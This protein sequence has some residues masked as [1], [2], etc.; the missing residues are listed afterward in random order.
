M[1]RPLKQNASYFSHDADM[2]NNRKIKALRARFGLEGYAVWCMTLECLTEEN[3]FV[4]PWDELSTELIS[5]D[6]GIAAESLAEIM[7]YMA[8]VGLLQISENRIQCPAHRARMQ[9]VLDERARKRDWKNNKTDGENPI[10]DG[11]NPQ[12]KGKET[13]GKEIKPTLAGG[14]ARA[15]VGEDSTTPA[16]PAA[17]GGGPSEYERIYGAVS[18]WAKPDDWAALKKI[19]AA[20]R[21]VGEVAPEVRRFVAHHLGKDGSREKIIA[22]PVRFF[23]EQFPGWLSLPAAKPRSGGQKNGHAPLTYP[24]A[25]SGRVRGILLGRHPNTAA[26]FTAAQIQR[27]ADAPNENCFWTWMEAMAKSLHN[28]N[29]PP[30]PPNEPETIKINGT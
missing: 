3:G 7:A 23:R 21:F 30:L 2:R 14:D 19:A 11:E 26:R 5:G 15:Q 18:E 6:F 24:I 16:I 22:D 4:L 12:T 25:D 1:A 29:G 13:K 27:L 10:K 20:A 28:G 8:R 9:F 17:I